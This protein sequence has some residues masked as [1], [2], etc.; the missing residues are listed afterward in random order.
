MAKLCALI[1]IAVAAQASGTASISTDTDL[2]ADR[3]AAWQERYSVPPSHDRVATMAIFKANEQFI[4]DFNDEATQRGSTMRLG[5][6]QF[7]AMTN[8]EYRV[9][10]RA[11]GLGRRRASVP[12]DAAE[13]RV[14][15]VGRP[16]AWNWVQQGVVS[17]VKNQGNCGSCWAFSAVAAM[18]GAFNRAHVNGTMPAQ[19]KS[20][21]GRENVTCCSFSEQ[22]V[23][24]C[25]LAGA[26]SCS[27]G[28]EPH[29]GILNIVANGGKINTDKQYPYTSGGSGKLTP[30]NVA[31]DPVATGITGYRNVT[32]GDEDALA[33]AIY[34]NSVISVG[35]DASQM[36]FQFYSKG[37][38]EDH[39]CKNTYDKLD[40]GVAVVGYGTGMAPQPPMP[41]PPPPGPQSCIGMKPQLCER[42]AGCHL[43]KDKNGFQYCDPD[44][45]TGSDNATETPSA[46]KAAAGADYWIVK[47]SW[48]SDWGV[49]G[50]IFM[51]RNQNNQCGIATDAVWAVLG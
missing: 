48:G 43:C 47:N 29:D 18:E 21:C 37:I 24:D 49:G 33:D 28:G 44:A 50:Y 36:T 46:V 7:G 30:C 17:P 3:F 8:D 15:S 27:K 10:I 26:D 14:S 42:T 41:P 1:S 16:D 23:A 20:L 5:M 45:C 2:V 38:Y 9:Y 12:T 6:N 40:H 32:S 22:E 4:S 13:P 35:I 39:K 25:T 31:A 11:N 34:A 51:S 19:C